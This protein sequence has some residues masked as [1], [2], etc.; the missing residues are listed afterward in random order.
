MLRLRCL[1]GGHILKKNP[2]L[3]MSHITGG[4]RST[5]FGPKG[6]NYISVTHAHKVSAV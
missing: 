3:K 4:L 1:L 5:L 2:T 6:I